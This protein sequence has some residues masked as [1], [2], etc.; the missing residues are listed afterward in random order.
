[1][2]D[3]GVEI[4]ENDENKN[5]GF[6]LLYYYGEGS[7][8][9]AYDRMYF[10]SSGAIEK[11]DNYIINVF[12][13]GS[14]IGVSC[15]GS[16]IK[17]F[18]FQFGV[19]YEDLYALADSPDK[20]VVL[21]TVNVTIDKMLYPYT[22]EKGTAKYLI[23]WN[24]P[25]SY[26]YYQSQ[27][28]PVYGDP[29]RF[30]T[31]QYVFNDYGWNNFEG[32]TYNKI[33]Y[34]IDQPF[35]YLAHINWRTATD[36]YLADRIE[37]SL[38]AWTRN[39]N[40][41]YWG[42]CDNNSGLYDSMKWPLFSLAGVNTSLSAGFSWE[43]A[44]YSNNYCISRHLRGIDI[45]EITSD[46]TST[47]TVNGKPYNVD[48]YTHSVS[49]DS[50]EENHSGQQTRT[51]YVYK[52]VVLQIDLT[53]S[54]GTTSNILKCLEFKE[55]EAEPSFHRWLKNN[56]VTDYNNMTSGYYNYPQYDDCSYIDLDLPSGNLWAAYNVGAPTPFDWG[57]YLAW[58]ETTE[59]ENYSQGSSNTQPAEQ[60]FWSWENSESWVVPNNSDWQE[61]VDECLWVWVEG[62]DGVRI[63]SSSEFPQNRGKIMYIDDLNGNPDLEMILR[64]EYIFLPISGNYS[65]TNI[66]NLSKGLYWASNSTSDGAY[67]LEFSTSNKQ[68]LTNSKWQGLQVRPV[69]HKSNKTLYID[70]TYTGRYPDGSKDNPYKHITD[71]LDVMN[72][73]LTPYTLM[74]TGNVEPATITDAYAENFKKITLR[75][76]KGLDSN[77][78]PQDAIVGN[79][80]HRP[81]TV[82]SGNIII[83]NLKLTGGGINPE[84]PD[85]S[86]QIALGG[87]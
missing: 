84:N 36:Y 83:K 73:A 82:N 40:N 18:S 58:G 64:G 48:K 62:E 53:Y 71:A 11:N 32:V 20:G 10:N 85:E 33:D 54:S 76:A 55:G 46:G 24:K 59:K 25:T 67:C 78:V 65:G 35:K 9:N 50:T 66:S 29:D 21:F 17:K 52:G 43:F 68:V 45:N 49:V 72:D 28:H 74:I 87:G 75:G 5:Y 3:A 8:V 60:P 70:A 22:T 44:D 23:R 63:Y 30:D 15:E 14:M 19:Q 69:V 13:E 86:S 31:I 51:F 12:S 37:K 81:L 16:D 4:D 38:M 41:G 47:I 57:D 1:M 7:F 39:S 56:G 42:Y 34:E 77:G 27:N 79:I 80:S 61:L 6:H 26:E 2:K